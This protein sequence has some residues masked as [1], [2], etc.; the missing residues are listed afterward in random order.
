MGRYRIGF[1]LFILLIISGK[2]SVAQQYEWVTGG[3]SMVAFNPSVFTLSTEA[4]QYICTD[5]AKNV[6]VLCDVA[7]TSVVAGSYRST[8]RH[9]SQTK[10]L[11]ASYECNGNLRWAKTF[12]SK[13]V[14][15][16]HGLQYYKGNLY[17]AG[18]FMGAE[19]Y[20]DSMPLTGADSQRTFLARVDT[21]GNLIWTRFAGPK[22]LSNPYYDKLARAG[23]LEIDGKGTINRFVYLNSGVQLGT[24]VTSNTNTYDVKY[25]TAGNIVGA[26]RLDT[27]TTYTFGNP[28]NHTNA[29]ISNS[30]RIYAV[31][32]KEVNGL[33]GSALCA[34]SPNGALIWDDTVAYQATGVA[35]ALMRVYY[36]GSNGLYVGGLGTGG[37]FSFEGTQVANTFSPT[38]NLGVIV[39]VDTNGSTKWIYA[40]ESNSNY[41][42]APNDIVRMPDGKLMAAY[43]INGSV[44]NG[45]VTF[46]QVS[47]FITPF[48]TIIDTAGKLSKFGNF[49]ST[50]FASGA[51]TFSPVSYFSAA[52]VDAAG[53]IYLGGTNRDTVFTPNQL[54]YKSGGG[55]SDFFLAK[56]G[57]NCSCQPPNASFIHQTG[58]A[59][60]NFT[61]TGTRPVDSVVWDFGDG[62]TSNQMNP[63]H[64][65]ANPNTASFT[66]CITVYT[67]C[68]VTISCRQLGAL[69][70][71]N[72]TQVPGIQMY[73]NPA[74]SFL[75]LEG[76][77]G[78]TA[79]IINNMGQILAVVSVTAD[80]QQTD[81]RSLP[82][83]I[84][85]V[86]VSDDAGGALQTSILVKE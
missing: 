19:R 10:L 68:G 40:N 20:F 79:H 16:A 72:S 51:T 70:I 54:F 62:A 52:T 37:K 81:I 9:G 46:P 55:V 57:Y 53:N 36:D 59:T 73:P 69:A 39:K 13:A 63:S 82:P 42:G 58:N 49:Y 38:D 23:A 34:F 2:E 67:S 22:G 77:K 48:Y 7:D 45:S 80:R 21:A 25:D 74:R 35:T 3:G 78:K 43:A 75:T 28:E 64:V 71:G 12:E 26:I 44:R 66:V 24:Y 31:L 84:Y 32:K 56:Y 1:F 76:A 60:V 4:V 41:A 5:E 85:L 61:Y 15:Y 83:G 11:L 47:T 65:Y 6:Y 8:D 27:D 18:A 29:R 50:G 86:R 30:G 33:R 17:V 14:V